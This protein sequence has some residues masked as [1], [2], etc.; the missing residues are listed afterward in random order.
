MRSKKA[1]LTI[2]L[3]EYLLEPAWASPPRGAGPEAEGMKT[4]PTTRSPLLNRTNLLLRWN[5]VVSNDPCEWCGER[6]DP[7][8]GW[9]YFDRDR[10]GA[11]VC[12]R[13][14]QK[15]APKLKQGQKGLPMN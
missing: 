11:L 4:F 13:C 5:I 14:V 7:V 2:A 1:V 6:T 8:H 12:D 3:Q 10:P 15:F 9:D